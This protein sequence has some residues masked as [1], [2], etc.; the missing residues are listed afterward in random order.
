MDSFESSGYFT[1]SNRSSVCS[2]QSIG[3]SDGSFTAEITTHGL[4]SSS[5]LRRSILAVSS[6][7]NLSTQNTASTTSSGSRQK[8]K[9][10]LQSE[11]ALLDKATGYHAEKRRAQ[12]A[13]QI[14]TT[15][16]YNRLIAKEEKRKAKEAKRRS[17]GSSTVSSWIGKLF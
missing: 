11:K 12:L 2:C 4:S 7:P 3:S 6:A 13:R 9:R 10:Y 1:T 17:G 16:Y 8:N 14:D 5:G 15:N